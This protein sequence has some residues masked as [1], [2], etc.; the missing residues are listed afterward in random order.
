MPEHLHDTSAFASGD[1]PPTGDRFKKIGDKGVQ[2]VEKLGTRLNDHIQRKVSQKQ[3]AVRGDEKK[4]I[5]LGGKVT[6]GALGATRK[7]VGAGASIA[8]KAT[9]KISGMVAK[10]MTNN[11]AS[12]SLSEAPDGSGKKRFHDNLMSGMLAFGRIYVAADA[13]GKLIIENAGHG[14]A[15]LAS[16]R[17]GDE[18]GN[19]SRQLA[20]I[21]LDGY[22]IARFPQKLGATSLLRGALKST[23]TAPYCSADMAQGGYTTPP[24]EPVLAASN[25]SLP[26]T[27][28]PTFEGDMNGRNS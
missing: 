28:A 25:G 21:A 6:A 13:H 11:S 2:L 27:V 26:Q 24:T 8:S 23:C 22:R 4:N 14:A 16:M 20:G 19:A 5:K 12:R 3:E 15:D 1:Q 18:A 10:G 9:E 17:Y 7:V